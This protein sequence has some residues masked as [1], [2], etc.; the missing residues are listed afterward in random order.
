MHWRILVLIAAAL[1]AQMGDAQQCPG[2]IYSFASVAGAGT[3]AGGTGPA[4]MALSAYGPC[5]GAPTG[6][7]SL[8][9][10]SCYTIFNGPSGSMNAFFRARWS[11]MTVKAAAGDQAGC[12]FS[13]GPLSCSV[14]SDG[15]PV[16]LLE[17]NI[18]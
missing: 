15:L 8:Q 9:P 13:C 11:N 3:S 5:P 10:S 4:I 12:R 2:N 16:E 7:T 1:F 18:D 14:K 17:W 6:P